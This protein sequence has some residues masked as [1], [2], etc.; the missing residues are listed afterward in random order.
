MAR[1]IIPVRFSFMGGGMPWTLE[2][3]L[4]TEWTS[5]TVARPY[6]EAFYWDVGYVEDEEW[7]VLPSPSDEWTLVA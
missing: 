3:D 7:T 2:G 5:A 6:V 1:I 4:S